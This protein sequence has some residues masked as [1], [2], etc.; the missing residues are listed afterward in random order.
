MITY[1]KELGRWVSS[2]GDNLIVIFQNRETKLYHYIIYTAKGKVIGK[3][4]KSLVTAK[5][6]IEREIICDGKN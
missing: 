4:S 5:R 1:K 6:R 2:H 3:L